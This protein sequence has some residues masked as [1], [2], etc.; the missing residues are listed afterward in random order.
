MEDVDPARPSR[1]PELSMTEIAFLILALA[2]R[3]LVRT[4]PA[5]IW[6]IRC[7]RDARHY[8]LPGPDTK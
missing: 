2:A 8:R 1:R 3:E 6:A 7:P 4:L 5:I